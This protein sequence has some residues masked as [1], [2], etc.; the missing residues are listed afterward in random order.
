MTNQNGR[1][2]F[3]QSR[4]LRAAL[5]D[6]ELLTEHEHPENCDP[7]EPSVREQTEGLS[8]QD[9]EQY[10]HVGSLND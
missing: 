6:S 4:L 8:G 1:S 10:D 5:V 3:F 9:H 7:V 2:L